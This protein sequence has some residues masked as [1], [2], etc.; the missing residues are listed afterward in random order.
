[1]LHVRSRSYIGSKIQLY[2][3]VSRSEAIVYV[4]VSACKTNERLLICTLT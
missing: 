2:L 3:E 4:Y 1:M